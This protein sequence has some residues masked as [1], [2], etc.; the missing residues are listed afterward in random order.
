MEMDEMMSG[1]TGKKSPF[2]SKKKRDKQKENVRNIKPEDIK[3]EQASFKM[4]RDDSLKFT[5]TESQPLQDLSHLFRTKGNSVYM[6][7]QEQYDKEE[8]EN[9]ARRKERRKN[10]REV[11]EKLK[12]ERKLRGDDTPEDHFKEEL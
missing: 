10:R 11:K 7:T 4:V 2:G 12:E 3:V 9:K 5:K 6:I 1:F 8:A